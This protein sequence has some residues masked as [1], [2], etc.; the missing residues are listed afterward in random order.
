MV[1]WESKAILCV[2]ACICNTWW[3]HQMETFST[4]LTLCAGKSSVTDEFSTQRPMTQSVDVLFYLRLTKQLTK[5]WRRRWSQM[6]S[7]LLWRHCNVYIKTHIKSFECFSGPSSRQSK[8]HADVVRTRW[9][10]Q[11]PNSQQNIFIARANIHKHGVEMASHFLTQN[12]DGF[13][14]NIDHTGPENGYPIEI[15]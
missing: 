8:S 13:L 15:Q 5:Q 3:R 7:C 4:L 11:I 14:Q 9:I 2:G 1:E 10:F 12:F 6:P